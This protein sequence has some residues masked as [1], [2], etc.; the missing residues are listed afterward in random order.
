MVLGAAILA[1][2]LLGGFSFFLKCIIII[3]DVHSKQTVHRSIQYTPSHQPLPIPRP[4]PQWNN[5]KDI[6]WIFPESFYL[7]I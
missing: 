7:D 5:T 3:Y 1:Y 6:W 2:P 4:V